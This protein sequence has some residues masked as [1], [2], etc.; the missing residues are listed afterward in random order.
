MIVPG[1]KLSFSKEALESLGIEVADILGDL[2]QQHEKSME[3]RVKAWQAYEAEKQ[4]EQKN[5]P[6]LGASNV[7]IPIVM[8]HVNATL[9]RFLMM[10]K[11]NENIWSGKSD[12]EEFTKKGYV[13]EIPRFLN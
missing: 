6:W 3:N 2:E 4:V 12:N 8:I 13:V 5:F 11:S 10:V 1:Q 7:M 9:A